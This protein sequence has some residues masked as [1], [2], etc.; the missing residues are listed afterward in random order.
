MRGKSAV[1][2]GRDGRWCDQ[3]VAATLWPLRRRNHEG[4]P[5]R[6]DRMVVLS[7]ARPG[8]EDTYHDWYNNV[9]APD[10]FHR[11]EGYATLQRYQLTERQL[12]TRRY[13]YVAIWELADGR[14]RDALTSIGDLRKAKQA[15]GHDPQDTP[16]PGIAEAPSTWFSPLERIDHP[17][18][19]ADAVDDC[20]LMVFSNNVPGT[21]DEFQ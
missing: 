9:H 19:S 6:P 16:N 12:T 10:V 2:D 7:N 3:S 14:L 17:T 8:E 11:R 4:A 21:D 13:G 20:L 1:P 18:D 15:G 5:M